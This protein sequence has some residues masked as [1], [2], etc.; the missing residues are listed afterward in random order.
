MRL[1]THQHPRPATEDRQR[2]QYQQ[3]IAAAGPFL[4]SLCPGRRDGLSSALVH[5]LLSILPPST[6]SPQLC[7]STETSPTSYV[8]GRRMLLDVALGCSCQTPLF[9]PGCRSSPACFGPPAIAAAAA[10]TANDLLIASPSS[11]AHRSQPSGLP[12]ATPSLG[13][14][15]IHALSHHR[16][17][18]PHGCSFET[19]PDAP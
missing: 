4:F 13:T 1:H 17:V 3:G 6:C 2:G 16:R 10:S 11:A 9:W 5:R 7:R 12:L 19:L 8:S 15:I 18:C 14:S